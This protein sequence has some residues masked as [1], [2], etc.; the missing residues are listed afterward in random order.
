MSADEQR[1]LAAIMFW[2]LELLWSLA[3]GVFEILRPLPSDPPAD[4]FA[5]ANV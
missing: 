3:L 1:K 5:V 2:I 4:G